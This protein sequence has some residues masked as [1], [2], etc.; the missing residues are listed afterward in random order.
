[1]NASSWRAYLLLLTLP[2][3]LACG[4]GAPPPQSEPSALS[5]QRP[6]IVMVVLCSLR[7]DHT[8]FGGY[9][10]PTT[11][12]LD[13]L[14]AEGV[15]FENAF[16]ASSW[17]KPSATSLFTGL[18]PNVHQLVDPYPIQEILAGQGAP[19]KVLPDSVVTLAET[20]KGA[21]Y[22][23]GCRVNNVNAG[24]FFNLTQGCDD[25]LTQHRRPA[26]Q[27]VDD[28]A[29][30]L[31][32]RDTTP[33]ATDKPFFFLLFALDAHVPY[34]PTHEDFLRFH[35]GEET[36][37]A[38]EFI[39]WRK[40]INQRANRAVA[41]SQEAMSPE[42]TEAL[43]QAYVDLYDAS[44]F[45]LDRQLA[46]LPEVLEAAGVADDTLIVVT[47]DH[48]ESFFEP[49]RQGHALTTHGYDLA[50]ALIRIPMVF[51]WPALDAGRRAEPVVRSIDLYPTLVDLAGAE[52][53]TLLQGESLV[54][55]LTDFDRALQPD[56]RSRT[57]FASRA[58]GKHHALHDGRHKLQ[59]RTPD[60]VS[61]FDTLED[62][63]EVNDLHAAEGALTRRLKKQL[64]DWL[65]EEE[66]LAAIVGEVGNRDLTPEMIE[67]LKSLGYL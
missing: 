32:R 17:T 36:V 46:R 50:E 56:V 24:D 62:P 63:H 20:L 44:V 28:L 45:G 57:A 39:A 9:D 31:E 35:R 13:R 53:P 23:T 30:M 7:V 4:D 15:V 65:E 29:A 64:Q 1:M 54:P 42:L 14:A 5:G 11:P 26:T 67:Q 21:G 49:G 22:D 41:D 60:H 18:T 61:L 19:P 34:S 52:A 51:H 37:D 6:N 47:A 27:M 10:R 3:L 2:W 43:Q 40:S 25:N 59:L 55:L 12:F 58:A 38:D 48:G 16:S 8:G 33:G 66:A